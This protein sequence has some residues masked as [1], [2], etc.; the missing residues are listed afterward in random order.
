MPTLSSDFTRREH[1]G[2][3]LPF[4]S[5]LPTKP[6]ALGTTMADLAVA[7]V[8]VPTCAVT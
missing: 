5:R 3:G 4:S 2:K 6:L 1:R 7:Q 8:I